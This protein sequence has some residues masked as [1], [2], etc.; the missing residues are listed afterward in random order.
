[1]IRMKVLFSSHMVYVFITWS[2]PIWPIKPNFLMSHWNFCCGVVT[3][4]LAYQTKFSDV[5]LEFL[6]KPFVTHVAIF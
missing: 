4:N 6:F 5:T 2:L 3:S 1:M